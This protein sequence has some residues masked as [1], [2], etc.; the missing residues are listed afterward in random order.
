MRN[1]PVSIN[2]NGFPLVGHTE[3]IIGWRLDEV[4]F[5]YMRNYD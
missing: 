1:A 3:A 4:G 2:W 5:L